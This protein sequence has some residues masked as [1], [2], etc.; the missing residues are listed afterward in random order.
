MVAPRPLGRRP[1]CWRVAVETAECCAEDGGNRHDQLR[2]STTAAFRRGGRFWRVAVR[3]ARSQR[4]RHTAAA[5]RRWPPGTPRTAAERNQGKEEP[6]SL[7]TAVRRGL[8]RAR[9]PGAAPEREQRQRDAAG[10]TE[11]GG[12]TADSGH[13]SSNS[14][15]RTRRKAAEAA[16]SD[17]TGNGSNGPPESSRVGFFLGEVSPNP[18]L[19]L[20]CVLEK[21]G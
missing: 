17:R 2:P 10:S 11:S 1:D 15:S 12:A 7:H 3:R 4:L 14:G 9:F 18:F 21:P 20:P 19:P 5:T 6:R 13:S 8:P 16:A